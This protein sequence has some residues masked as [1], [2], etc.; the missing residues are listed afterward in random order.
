M[1]AR[2]L[3]MKDKAAYDS[4]MQ[5]RLGRRAIT[6]GMHIVVR[7][8]TMGKQ[9]GDRIGIEYGAVVVKDTQSGKLFAKAKRLMVD[10]N[11]PLMVSLDLAE[12]DMLY[13]PY[14]PEHEAYEKPIDMPG[15]GVARFAAVPERPSRPFGYIL[16][17][18]FA[19]ERI[20]STNKRLA[21]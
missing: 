7:L 15:R 6:E 20:V 9:K 19:A 5:H 21:A 10:S 11:I 3:S 16:P 13:S 1:Y 2:A 12:D 17:E 18:E 14:V 4:D 8:L